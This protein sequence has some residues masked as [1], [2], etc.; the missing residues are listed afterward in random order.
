MTP[1]PALAILAGD[2]QPRSEAYGNIRIDSVRHV[3]LAL[4]GWTV[5]L[6]RDHT[7]IDTDIMFSTADVPNIAPQLLCCATI[8]AGPGPRPLPGTIVPG[9]HLPVM[10]WRVGRSTVNGEPILEIDVPGNVTL[11]FQFPASTAQ[12]CA[13]ALAAEGVAASP[14]PGTRPN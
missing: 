2:N 6:G 9:C 4:A 13:Q 1:D 8:E 14:S 7:G 5:V 12:A 11:R 3:R 10:G